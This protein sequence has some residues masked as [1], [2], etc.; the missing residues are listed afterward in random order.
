MRTMGQMAAK[1]GGQKFGKHA[2][3]ETHHGVSGMD[4]MATLKEANKG[5]KAKSR[6]VLRGQK[7]EYKKAY[8][9]VGARMHKTGVLK[10]PG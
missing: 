8:T 10:A 4:R 2:Y 5:K 6:V 7:N 9:K 3:G 1:Q